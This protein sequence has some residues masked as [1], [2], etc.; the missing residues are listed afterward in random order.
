[1][2]IKD[3]L[4]GKRITVR[5]YQSSDLDFVGGIWFDKENGRYLSDPEK[6][7]IDEKFQKA[8]DGLEDSEFGYY[9][10]A[11]LTE[12]GDLVGTCCAFPDSDDRG[13]YDI[14]YCVHKAYWRKGYG[15]EIVSVLLNWIK[16]IGGTRVTAEAAREN[17]ASC[18]LLEKLGF[19][20]VKE[21][22][23]KKY[24]MNICYDSFIYKKEI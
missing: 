7:Y 23:F 3:K 10:V 15:S 11:E 12:T 4:T 13:I 2:K 20:I 9:F 5:S 16:S 6:E 24:N 19:E 22:S 17:K 1:M 21:G 8:V 14:G 18:A